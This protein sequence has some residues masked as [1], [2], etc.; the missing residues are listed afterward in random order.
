MASTRFQ[1]YDHKNKSANE[2]WFR[3]NFCLHQCLWEEYP[4]AHKDALQNIYEEIYLQSTNLSSN[5][6][7]LQKKTKI[8]IIPDS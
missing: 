4:M 5:L 7:Y 6:P 8:P 3:E 2:V 1:F